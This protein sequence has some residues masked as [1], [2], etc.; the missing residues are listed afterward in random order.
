MISIRYIAKK[1]YEQIINLK[2]IGFFISLVTYIFSFNEEEPDFKIEK[3]ITLFMATLGI[4]VCMMFMVAISTLYFYIPLYFCFVAID[5]LEYIIFGVIPAIKNNEKIPV[6]FGKNI[7]YFETKLEKLLYVIICI[8]Y[9]LSCPI[10]IICVF[11]SIIMITILGFLFFKYELK[12]IFL[13]FKTLFY[14]IPNKYHIK[15]NDIKIIFH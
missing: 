8:I 10:I 12:L 9:I 14:S 4:I 11:A 2:C 3:G 7:N 6:I 5:L 1:S 13:I 15:Y